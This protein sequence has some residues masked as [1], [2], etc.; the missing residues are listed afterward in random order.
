MI[1]GLFSWIFRLLCC[2]M[3]FLF[4]H[5][6]LHLLLVLFFLVL[7]HFLHVGHFRFAH[8]CCLKAPNLGAMRAAFLFDE[9]PVIPLSPPT[10]SIPPTHLPPSGPCGTHT[11]VPD[12]SRWPRS[13]Q[14]QTA[15]GSLK[16]SQKSPPPPPLSPL[17]R[18]PPAFYSSSP[19]RPCCLQVFGFNVSAAKRPVTGGW[20][21]MTFHAVPRI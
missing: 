13:L 4:I 2:Y 12:G 17:S 8:G 10:S 6:H 19:Q 14:V 15:S 1:N 7:F 5:L 16:K 11:M 3:F 9:S 21:P 20:C 18:P